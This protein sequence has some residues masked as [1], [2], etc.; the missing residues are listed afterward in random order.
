MGNTAEI[1]ASPKL[2]VMFVIAATLMFALW[3]FAFRSDFTCS[4]ERLPGADDV[5]GAP[6]LRF[7]SLLE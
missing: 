2:R 3:G 4:S 1:S 5:L 6:A 7:F